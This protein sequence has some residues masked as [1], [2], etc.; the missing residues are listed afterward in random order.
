ML[1]QV[2]G[3]QEVLNR[4]KNVDRRLAGRVESGLK[5]CGLHLLRESQKIVPVQTGI[6]KSTGITRKV[7]G[8]GFSTD[9]VVSYG[10]GLNVEPHCIYAVLV[11]EIPGIDLSSPVTHG[12][13]FNIKHAD[14][15]ATTGKMIKLKSGRMK[16]KP[17][18]TAGTAAGGMFPRRKEEQYKFLEKPMREGRDALLRI[19]K[20]EGLLR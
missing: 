8:M 13:L 20:N 19:L 5:K 17:L 4:L 6:L 11:H 10:A 18:T 3:V 1:V 12:E 15:I 9:V 14:E 16:W 7:S 2:K